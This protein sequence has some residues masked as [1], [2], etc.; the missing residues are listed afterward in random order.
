MPEWV[1]VCV[2]VP[3]TQNVPELVC[4]CVCVCVCV[5]MCVCAYGGGAGRL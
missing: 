2:S 1:T 5:S 3:D 4:V